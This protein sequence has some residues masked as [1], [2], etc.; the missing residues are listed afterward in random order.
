MLE[1]VSSVKLIFFSETIVEIPRQRPQINI[2]I[3]C[4]KVI[5]I[6]RMRVKRRK[7][8]KENKVDLNFYFMTLL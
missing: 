8:E 7:E 6:L 2:G 4:F 1:A 3:P 5:D